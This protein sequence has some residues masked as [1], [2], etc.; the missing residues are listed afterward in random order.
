MIDK[1]TKITSLFVILYWLLSCIVLSDVIN[2]KGILFPNWIDKILF[3]G[4]F[5]GFVLSL[6]GGVIFALIGQLLT[7]S[8]AILFLRWI[9]KPHGK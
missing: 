5:V 7:L 2:G 9:C 4:Y 8:I 3:S 1:K 6:V